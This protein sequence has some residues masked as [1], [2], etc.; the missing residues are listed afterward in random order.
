MANWLSQRQIFDWKFL[1]VDGR[2]VRASNGML[3]A[4]DTSM[5]AE[6]KFDLVLVVASFEAKKHARNQ[7]LN[8]WLRR[9]ARFGVELGGIETGSEALA[10]AG[11][12]DGRSVA[13]HW[14]N[15]DGFRELF[16]TC[17]VVKQLYTIDA[18]R[19]T[20]AG[21]TAVID[22]I[23]SWISQRVSSDLAWE[24]GQQLLMDSIRAPIK[25]QT[26]LTDGLSIANQPVREAIEIMK[27]TVDDP[28]DFDEIA[29]QVGVSRRQI[30]R[31]FRR[32]LGVSPMKYYSTIRLA[33]AHQLLQQTDLPVTEIAIS[34][35]F[36]SAEHF[37][38]VYRKAFER[39][40]SRDRLQT[41][42]APVMRPKAKRRT[43][44]R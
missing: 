17:R 44:K 10:V 33:K 32:H 31:H 4:V 18:D 9:Q 43:S 3:T 40:P 23:L 22:M 42:D 37:S 20:C 6:D 35:G 1:S 41:Y 28:L 29:K 38:R 27:R 25:G 39:A 34:S 14:E 21:A 26:A 30:E 2:P 24:I 12:L 15:A 13:V 8:N 7:R 19:L 5:S 11:L 16:P 36:A